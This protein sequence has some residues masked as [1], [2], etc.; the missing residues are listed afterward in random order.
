MSTLG[1]HWK[2][3]EQIRKRLSEI[4]KI[5]GRGSK[6]KGKKFSNQH[7]K[8]LS[9]SCRGRASSMKGKYHSEETKRKISHSRKGQ[10]LSKEARKKVALAH[11]GKH[12]SE[13]TKK[14]ISNSLRGRVFLEEHKRRIGEKSKGRNI[15]EKSG[16]WK[17]GITPVNKTIRQSLCSNLWRKSCL[18]RDNF[19]CQKCGQRGGELNAHHINNFAEFPESRTTIENGIVL[20]KRCHLN[21]HKKYGYKNNTKEQLEE[22]LKDN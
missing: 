21:F 17:G 2:L 16:R 4:A 15:G 6:Q 13:E 10:H 14:K 12:L 5:D 11:K 8:R 22:F 19:T 20:C 9:E 1:K 3:S 7:R 18:E